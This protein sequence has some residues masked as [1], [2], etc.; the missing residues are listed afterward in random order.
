LEEGGEPFPAGEDT[1]DDRDYTS[2]PPMR[3]EKIEAEIPN[4]GH[5]RPT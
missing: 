1:A 3:I 4:L 5:Q 2:A